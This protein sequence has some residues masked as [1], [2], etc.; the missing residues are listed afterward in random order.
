MNYISG[1]L[2]GINKEVISGNFANQ[3]CCVHSSMRVKLFSLYMDIQILKGV[4]YATKGQGF[5][6]PIGKTRI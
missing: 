2:K 4:T 5:D 1:F 6:H 3:L